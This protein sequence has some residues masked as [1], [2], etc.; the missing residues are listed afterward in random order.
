MQTAP[1]T[2]GP[3]SKQTIIGA[4]LAAVMASGATIGVLEIRDSPTL[5]AAAAE[6]AGVITVKGDELGV[7]GWRVTVDKPATSSYTFTGRADRWE[8]DS[9]GATANAIGLEKGAVDYRLNTQLFESGA[10]AAVSSYTFSGRADRWELD[11]AGVQDSQPRS[12]N[13]FGH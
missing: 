8:L 10:K 4:L 3:I 13:S 5:G 6:Q 1:T 2:V 11:S 7:N 9:T 12:R